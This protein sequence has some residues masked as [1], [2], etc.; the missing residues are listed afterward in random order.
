MRF[1]MRFGFI[2]GDKEAL[3]DDSSNDQPKSKNGK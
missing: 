2:G 1:T 3:P